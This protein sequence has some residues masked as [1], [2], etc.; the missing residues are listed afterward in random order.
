[1]ITTEEKI[2]RK[3]RAIEGRPLG[4][5]SHTEHEGKI[6][7]GAQAIIASLEAEG[8][9]TIFGYPGGQAIKIY[10]A[11]YDS[12]KIH[13]I[14]ARHEQ[15]AVHEADGYAR[16][17]GKVGVVLVTSGPGATNTVTG[18]ATAY[19]D[20]V[21]L[22]VITGQVTRGV[23]GTDSFQ[24]SDIVGITMPVVKHSYLLQST[25]DLTRT[26][27]EVFYRFNWA[28]WPRAYR[29]PQRSFWGRNGLPLSR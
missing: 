26:F 13:H 10:D 11:L 25:D 22:V 20:S 4:P 28:S 24:E 29:C 5:G 6:M 12:K 1:M 18:I 3:R 23:I 17:T 21:P 19:M 14:L 27:R 16:S 15:A 7:T 2:E 8:V 9:D